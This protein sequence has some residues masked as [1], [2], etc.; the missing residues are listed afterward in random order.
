MKLMVSQK[1]KYM[2][3][4]PAVL[5]VVVMCSAMPVKAGLV[6]PELMK[7]MA[8]IKGSEVDFTEERHNQLLQKPMKLSGKLIYKAPNTLIKQTIKPLEETFIISGP[9]L[10]VERMREGKMQRHEVILD[11]F[12][13][14]A[15]IVLGLR[16]VLSGDLKTLEQHYL[17]ELTG[18]YEDWTLVLKPRRRAFE[19]DDWLKDVVKS[20][21]IKGSGTHVSRVEILE[22]GGDR[23]ITRIK[24]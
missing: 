17:P 14:L 8:D 18:I 4:L 11:D 10:A 7:S 22:P 21:T 12:P 13:A 24:H 1:N 2:A 23:S 6:L 5:F 3:Q 16:S 15:P 9:T 20:V 19:E